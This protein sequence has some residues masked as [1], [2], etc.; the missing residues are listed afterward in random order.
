MERLTRKQANALSTWAG[1]V[2]MVLAGSFMLA[3]GG[4]GHRVQ[5][6]TAPAEETTLEVVLEE[7]GVV[8]STR[9][10]N[11]NSPFRGRIVHILDSG[12]EVSEGD[13]VALLDVQSLEESLENQIENLKSIRNELESAVEEMTMTL[14]S[15]ALDISS[16]QAELDLTRVEL[17]NVN[18]ELSELEYLRSRDLVAEDNVRSAAFR[19]R[20]SEISTYREDMNLRSRV[21]GSQTSELSNQTRLERISVR[22]SDTLRRI[23]ETAQRIELAEIRSPAEG[24]FLRHSRWDW[25][26]RRNV[27]RQSG[28]EVSERDRLGEIPDINHLVVRSQIPESEMLNVRV[29]TPVELSFEAAGNLRIPGSVRFVA[30]LAVE[31]ETSPGGQITAS[32]DQLTGEKV[33]EIEIAMER[34]DERLRPGL[35]ARARFVLDRR[36][37]VLTVP[38][39]A[40]NTTSAGRHF[41]QVVNQGKREER[42]VSLGQSCD[43]RVEVLEGLRPGEQVII[44]ADRRS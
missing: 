12:T 18:Q 3:C 14:R 15:N 39:E 8:D 24:L 5:M 35:S 43:R 20:T 22:A 36:D 7:V 21:T 31:R 6:D 13:V 32:G 25:S 16:A 30:P 4:S 1:A 42:D 34:M 11:I 2:A 37:D 10:V 38:L 27:E 33:F 9:V 23:G 44:G 41:V 26:S 19:L 28:Q 17:A 29:G 40:I